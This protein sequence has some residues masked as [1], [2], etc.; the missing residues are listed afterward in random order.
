MKKQDSHPVPL[1]DE[2]EED[3]LPGFATPDWPDLGEGELPPERPEGERWEVPDESFNEN[4]ASSSPRLNDFLRLYLS[5]AGAY[6]L[7]TLEEEEVELARR[8]W[9]GQETAKRLGEL[10]GL[11]HGRILRAARARVLDERLTPKLPAP[12]EDEVRSTEALC[13]SSKEAR[14]LYQLVRDGEEARKRLVLANLRL[15]VSTTKP[16]WKKRKDIPFLDLIAEGNRGLIRATETFDYRKRIKF[17]THATWWIMQA[18]QRYIY[19]SSRLIRLPV[20]QEEALAKIR[21]AQGILFGRFCRSPSPEEVAEFLGGDWTAEAVRE[22]LV[23]GQEVYSLD[24]P[25]K[26]FDE[27]DGSRL[28]DLVPAE[29]KGP[30]ALAEAENLRQRLLQIL[31]SLSPK[32]RAVLTLRFGLETGTPFPSPKSGSAWGCPRS[33]CGRSKRRR[34]GACGTTP[35][36]F[37][38]KDFLE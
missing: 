11:D 13:R 35:R 32:Q 21:N 10:L 2:M 38:L 28:Q 26:T 6:E 8:V 20:H 5:E 1:S 4:E 36:V 15:V 24:E 30:E 29:G 37:A 16:M 33:G 12:S 22:R 27:N 23:F 25:A 34:F 19:G 31:D 14:R 17:S 9:E 7:L 3:L 18:A